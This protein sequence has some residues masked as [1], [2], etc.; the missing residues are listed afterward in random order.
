MP[1]RC[2][3]GKPLYEVVFDVGTLGDRIYLLCENH[4]NKK[5]FNKHIKSQTKIGDN[6]A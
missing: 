1:D 4:I 5:P 2:C 6:N 3:Y